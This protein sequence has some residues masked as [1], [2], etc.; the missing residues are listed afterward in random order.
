[1]TVAPRR[2][3]FSG[4]AIPGPDLAIPGQTWPD[5]D[6][7]GQIWRHQAHG[8]TDGSLAVAG[9]NPLSTPRRRRRR[10]VQSQARPPSSGLLAVVAAAAA[11]ATHRRTIATRRTTPPPRAGPPD[12]CG[13]LRP[14]LLAPPLLRRVRDPLAAFAAGA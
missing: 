6:R 7:F 11:A 8:T 13:M 3:F 4:P 14:K 10:R 5:L 9:A 1:M 12:Y 2:R